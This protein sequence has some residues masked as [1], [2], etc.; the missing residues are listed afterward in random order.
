MDGTTVYP[1][2]EE[3]AGQDITVSEEKTLQAESIRYGSVEYT[4]LHY[5][6]SADLSKDELQSILTK[7]NSSSIDTQYKLA[8]VKKVVESKLAGM[9]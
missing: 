8:E 4:Y 5:I 9:E 1:S 7:I 6:Q 2:W 3:Y